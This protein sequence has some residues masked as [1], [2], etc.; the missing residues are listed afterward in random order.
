M[1]GINP[2]Q[3]NAGKH[4]ERATRAGRARWS[5]SREGRGGQRPAAVLPGAFMFCSGPS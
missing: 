5:R 4:R 3:E 2:A 1:A